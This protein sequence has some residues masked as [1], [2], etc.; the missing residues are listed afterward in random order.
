MQSKAAGRVQM[1]RHRIGNISLADEGC[2]ASGVVLLAKALDGLARW[3]DGGH[4]RELLSSNEIKSWRIS[5]SIAA[6]RVESGTS[7]CSRAV[8]LALA[9][10]QDFPTRRLNDLG[11]G[12]AEMMGPPRVP[13]NAGCSKPWT[14]IA[15]P[16]GH[17][18]R[19]SCGRR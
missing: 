15:E 16:F 19:A 9:L 2:C 1:L 17:V 12:F 11:S 8:S 18:P 4:A 14:T 6:I 5:S 3:M 7:A 13:S 10:H